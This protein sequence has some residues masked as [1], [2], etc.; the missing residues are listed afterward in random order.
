MYELI[1]V[2]PHNYYIDCPAKIGVVALD[3]T[4][5]CLI[6]SGSDKDA[7]RKIRQILDQ[8]NWHLTAIFNTHSH[9]DHIGG[10]RY[11][12]AQTGCHVYAYGIENAFTLYPV[13]EPSFLYGG[14]PVKELRQKFLLAQG[15]QAEPLTDAALPHGMTMFPLPGHS[16][17]MV[18]F[19]T[20]ENTVYLADC[21]SSPETLEKYGIVF[22]YDVGQHLETLENIKA[23]KSSCFIP[24]HAA[25]SGSITDLADI[26]IAAVYRNADTIVSLCAEPVCFDVLLQRVFDA[27]GLTMTHQQY[28][29]IGSTLRSYLAYLK[30]SQRIQMII[31]SNMILWKS[32]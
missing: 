21:L 2:S 1:Q 26:N 7:G 6:D 5:V 27:Y 30:E 11:L 10:N 16:F 28:V 18:G 13:L 24:A 8:H 4:N 19:K 31:D 25:V 20:D 29:L 23:L 17:D 3:D 32:V 22:L 9:A 12:Q 15:S 14:F